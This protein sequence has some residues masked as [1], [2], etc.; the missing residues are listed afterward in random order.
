MKSSTARLVTHMKN[1]AKKDSNK[2]TTKGKCRFVKKKKTIFMTV[3]TNICENVKTLCTN[4]LYKA[5]IMNAKLE[6]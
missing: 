6:V 1:S 2:A 3:E 4:N 5:E